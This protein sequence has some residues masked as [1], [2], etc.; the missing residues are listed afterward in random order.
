MGGSIGLSILGVKDLVGHCCHGA[1]EAD[2]ARQ[3]AV[4]IADLVADVIDGKM[5]APTPPPDK[6]YS[7]KFLVWVSPEL[8]KKSVLKAMARGESLNQ[9]VSEALVEA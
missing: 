5:P 8:H 4:I 3:L 9:F 7:G 2:V 6:V 1:T